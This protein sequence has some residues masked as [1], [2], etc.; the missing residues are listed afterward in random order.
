MYVFDCFLW[1]WVGKPGDNLKPEST[2]LPQPASNPL[3]VC[4][5]CYWA[6]SRERLISS[7]YSTHFSRVC[8][9]VYT[10]LTDHWKWPLLRAKCQST[11]SHGKLQDPFWEEQVVVGRLWFRTELKAQ[12]WAPPP[13]QLMDQESITLSEPHLP[14]LEH[15]DNLCPWTWLLRSLNRDV[16]ESA[17]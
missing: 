8:W 5:S 6:L 14:R 11:E 15:E 17:L 13:T 1:D 12:V 16:S 7:L 2:D 4:I 10:V 3:R 9:S